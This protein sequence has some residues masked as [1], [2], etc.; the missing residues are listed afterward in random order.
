MDSNILEQHLFIGNRKSR[1]I[2]EWSLENIFYFS[3]YD[4]SIEYTD[5]PTAFYSTVNDRSK[6]I[7]LDI[8][9][10]ERIV[11]ISGNFT[12][13]GNF[14]LTGS[15][16]KFTVLDTE[17]NYELLEDLK[18]FLGPIFPIW[19]FKNPYIW[20]STMYEDYERQHFFEVRQ[21]SERTQNFSDPELDIYRRDNGI[22]YK[23]RF[24]PRECYDV[25]EECFKDLT[26]IFETLRTN[27]IKRSYEGLEIFHLYCTDK[28]N[29]RRSEPRTKIAKDI[30][31][32]LSLEE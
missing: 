14:E 17:Y 30:K 13:G 28:V 7:I 23:F 16:L 32:I 2:L 24:Y 31:A 6:K 21:Y 15:T 22:I 9:K 12:D 10:P 3:I 26:P 27:L 8:G 11:K 25:I 4:V 18:N 29:F 20:G 5:A 19:F 1:E